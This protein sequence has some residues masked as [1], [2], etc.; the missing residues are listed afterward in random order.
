M[1]VVV[2]FDR[3]LVKGRC[4]AE[5]TVGAHWDSLRDG[6]VPPLR[7]QIRAAALGAHLDRVF[8][9]QRI[10]PGHGRLRLSGGALNDILGMDLR[11]MPVSALFTGADRRDLAE[12]LEDCWQRPSIVTIT[13]Q[14][15]GSRGHLTLWPMRSDLGDTSRALGCLSLDAATPAP[16]LRLHITR[17]SHE[18]LTTNDCPKTEKP[19]HVGAGLCL[20]E[21]EGPLA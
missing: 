16:L 17:I 7:S 12:A 2:Q 9:L 10:A 5:A 13:F 6:A 18:P 20:V 8:L 11:G 14:C 19:A 1:G 21:P 3:A 15:N 4:Q